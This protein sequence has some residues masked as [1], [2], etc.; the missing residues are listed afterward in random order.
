MGSSSPVAFIDPRT[1]VLLTGIMGGL[2]SI[3]LY[4]LRRNYPPS[5]KGLGDWSLAWEGETEYRWR[6]NDSTDAAL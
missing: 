5:V 6:A 4:F 3:V 1:I 2:M